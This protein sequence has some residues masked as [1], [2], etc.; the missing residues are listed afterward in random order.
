MPLDKNTKIIAT[1]GPAITDEK[2]ISALVLAGVDSFRFNFSHVEPKVFK[3]TIKQI[4]K[5]SKDKG[6]SIPL[7]QDLQGPKI[8]LNKF[9]KEQALCDGENISISVCK[10]IDEN[11]DKPSIVL[12][13]LEK[14]IKKKDKI[15]IDDGKIELCVLNIKS[16]N[17]ECEV[18]K[19]GILKPR[20]GVNLP[21]T[22]LSLSTLTAKDLDDLR[23]GAKLGFDYVALSFV[24]SADDIIK[25]KKE[26]KKLKF[27]AGLIS[28]IEKPEAL[29]DIKRIVQE[30][31]IVLIARGDLGVEV[32]P[33]KVPGIQKSII[34][35]CKTEKTPV[36]V[37]TQMLESMIYN[38]TPTRAEVTDV[39]Q[40][41][42]DSADIVML[43]GETAVGKYPVETVKMMKKIIIEAELNMNTCTINKALELDHNTYS[44]NSSSNTIKNIDE[45]LAK[46][47][48]VM[49]DQ[50]NASFICAFT[51]SG[52]TARLLSKNG[53]H[54]PI[55]AF[56][57]DEKIKRKIN[58]YRG[59]KAICMKKKMSSLDQL[60]SFTNK[61]L[62]Q[63]KLV[64]TN[65]NVV[66]VAGHPLGKG[67]MTNLLKVHKI[68]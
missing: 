22:K 12:E 57:P 61:E 18:I 59:V 29:K 1:I 9:E 39:Y 67:G 34:E 48:A 15:L 5:I 55:I 47:S 51:F 36:I 58:L 3:K 65:D 62:K 46:L 45:E 66:I 38:A 44:T 16:K 4:R 56:T 2:R 35:L 26:L 17:I 54:H 52:W 50:I 23:F 42:S 13:G 11:P 8:R 37:A 43:S 6:L 63:L 68:I 25:L 21:D 33:E 30:S 40:A 14:Q 32:S 41:V 53:T 49:S 20:K 31:D 7:I 64:K 19:G 10:N 60:I 28:K 27:D 24:R